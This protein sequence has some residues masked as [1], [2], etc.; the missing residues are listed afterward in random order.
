MD[1]AAVGFHNELGGRPLKVHA[2]G[3]QVAVD[4]GVRQAGP[5]DQLQET[6]LQLT[7]GER[8]LGK[9]A[10]ELAPKL[11]GSGAAGGSL[12]GLGHAGTP[13]ELA[14][15]GLLDGPVEVLRAAARYVNQGPFDP[16]G[17]DAVTACGVAERQ[18]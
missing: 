5:P 13:D 10:G 16:R 12:E 15:E 9:E 3:L 2:V 17:R 6:A 7:A 18:Q 8:E 4:D 14:D 1:A 11:G